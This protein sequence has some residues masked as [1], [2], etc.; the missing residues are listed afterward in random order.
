MKKGLIYT[1]ILVAIFY[2]LVSA[3]PTLAFDKP[4]L[5]CRGTACTFNDL[6]KFIAN[7]IHDLLEIAILLAVIFIIYGGFAIMT[8]GGSADKAQNGR[9]IITAAAI[10]AVIAL[11]SWLIVTTVQNALTGF[12]K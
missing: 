1:F 7:V 3:T 8:A 12:F 11:A 2:F 4:L 9:K 5:P 10:G 6:L